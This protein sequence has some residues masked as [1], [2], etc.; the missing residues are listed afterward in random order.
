M[1]LKI[2]N[3]YTNL[4][5]AWVMM[6]GSRRIRKYPLSANQRAEIVSNDLS[7]INF[8]N[9]CSFELKRFSHSNQKI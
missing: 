4:I 7:S 8:L 5:I 1:L 6:G 9:N 2:N 3:R